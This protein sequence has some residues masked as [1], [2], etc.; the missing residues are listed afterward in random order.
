MA[1]YETDNSTGT[2]PTGFH[3]IAKDFLN[4]FFTTFPEYRESVDHAVLAV[5]ESDTA[6]LDVLFTHMKSVF[7]QR[8]FDILY[9]NQDMFTDSEKNTEFLPGIDF[10]LIWKMEDVTES[11]RDTLWKY[12]QLIMFSILETIQS[13]DSFGD[14]AKLFEAI[15]EEELKS[16]N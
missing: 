10:A 1:S 4:D 14:T 15:N 13:Q 2:I 3:Q 5:T 12:L 6:P 11:T 9:K 8:F 7:P 16:K